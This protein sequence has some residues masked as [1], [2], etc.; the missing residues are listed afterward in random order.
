LFLAG[1]RCCLSSESRSYRG[2]E[3]QRCGGADFFLAGAFLRLR[4]G[5]GGD[6]E[7]RRCGGAD[8]FLADAGCCLSSEIRRCRRFQ[9]AVLDIEH[10]VP[11]NTKHQ[12]LDSSYI[13]ELTDSP[14]NLDAP[15]IVPS[16]FDFPRSRIQQFPVD[17]NYCSLA[18][19]RGKVI[20]SCAAGHDIRW[21][22]DGKDHCHE[23][24]EFNVEHTAD[25]IGLS[26]KI[27][28]GLIR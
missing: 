15:G 11:N 28:I 27:W 17:P 6:G 18:F 10:N 25:A 20:A 4:V 9:R 19:R 23:F 21:Q 26:V 22:M 3:I 14:V 2:A 24:P 5:E 1:A 8:F 7:I 12:T 13:I 16:S